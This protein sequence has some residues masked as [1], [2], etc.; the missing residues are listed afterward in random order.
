[1]S[2]RRQGTRKVPDTLHRAVKLWA[3]LSARDYRYPNRKPFADRGG[4]Q[5][6]EQLPN[7]VNGPLAP[8]W[9]EIFMGFPLGWT[10][11][12]IPGSLLPAPNSS[13]GNLP[14]PSLDRA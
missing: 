14:A 7:Q 9:C 11:P 5:K 3:T 10:D 8:A 6:G 12:D 2:L 1:M 4:G 13:L